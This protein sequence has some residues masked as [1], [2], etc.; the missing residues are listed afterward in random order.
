MHD[1]LHGKIGS[2]SFRIERDDEAIKLTLKDPHGSTTVAMSL[3]AAEVFG[4]ALE[5]A[6]RLWRQP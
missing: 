5:A 3:D 1:K 2:G 4:T 6:V